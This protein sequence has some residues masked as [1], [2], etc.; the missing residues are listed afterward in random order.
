MIRCGAEQRDIE[1]ATRFFKQAVEVVGQAPERVTTDGHDSSPRAIPETRGS[2]VRQRTN[3]DLTTRREQDHRGIQQRYAPMR[4]F[5]SVA[6]AA[7]FCGA[8][9]EFRTELRPRQRLGETVSLP[10]QRRVF[11]ERLASLHTLL[12]AAS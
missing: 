7:R 2:E 12:L 3:A 4:G 10:E 11:R 5:G 1:A 6:S 9:D 8:C